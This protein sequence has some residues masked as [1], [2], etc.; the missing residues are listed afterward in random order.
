M[1]LKSSNLY[2]ELRYIYRSIFVYKKPISYLYHRFFLGPKIRRFTT[3]EDSRFPGNAYSVHLLCGHKDL[4]MLFWSLASWYQAV[5]QSGQVYIHD[6]GTF[7]SKDKR[8]ISKM[9]PYAAIVDYQETTQHVLAGLAD[10]F[11]RAYHYRNLSQTDRRY[12]FNLK[13]IDPFFVGDA[14]T[15]LIIDSDLLWFQRPQKLLEAIS[16]K[17]LPIFMGG[18][19]SM[20][21]VFADG[22]ELNKNIGGVNSGVV[23]YERKQFSLDS[24]EEFY[25]RVGSN[26]NPHF[27]EQAGYAYILTRGS[28]PIFLPADK[29][30]IKGSVSDQTV[31]KHY[32]SPRR[33]QFW[34]EGVKRLKGG[35]LKK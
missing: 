25:S 35:I 19:G 5:A 26:A 34:F 31:M 20:D 14:G 6:D 27:V 15:K 22:S 28:E 3:P 10:R 18:E 2:R 17:R 13:L 21:F 4:Q 30:H 29:Y 24:L 11:P 8:I 23:G 32:T 7:N 16:E 12:I 33:E 1:N 9:F